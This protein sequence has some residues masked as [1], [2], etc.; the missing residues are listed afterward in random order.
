MT[1]STDTGWIWKPTPSSRS[2]RATTSL[3]V[4][5][6]R[7]IAGTATWTLDFAV[8]DTQPE[9]AEIPDPDPVEVDEGI[10]LSGQLDEP[11]TVTSGEQVVTVDDEHRFELHFDLPPSRPGGAS[12]PRT[13]RGNLA[14][15]AVIVPVDHDAGRG[16]A[17][18]AESWSDPEIRSR[19]LDLVES[20][21]RPNRRD[22]P[23][24][25][26]AGLWPGTT[27]WTWP[28]RSAPPPKPSSSATPWM[29]C[30]TAG[31]VRR[32]GRGVP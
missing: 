27:T 20:G 28:T 6:P 17:L 15:A 29:R 23:S 13:E 11:G 3:T 7:I 25:T 19:V 14:Q 4:T 22:H 26:S 32:A 8:D 12:S 2:T 30:T 16:L 21:E 24:R 31:A 9:F 5:V 1:E 10:T 18:S